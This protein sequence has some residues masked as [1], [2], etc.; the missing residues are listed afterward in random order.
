MKIIFEKEELLS[1]LTPAMSA[2]SEKNTN[3]AI[4]GILFDAVSGGECIISSYDLEKGFRVKVEANVIEGGSYIIPA[5]KLFRIIKSMP[6]NSVSIEVNEKNLVKIVSGKSEFKLS[7]ING[8]DF[9][10]MP[11]LNIEI[12]FGIAGN[13]LK[14]TIS[15]IQHAIAQNEQ[16]RPVMQGAYF[17]LSNN[18]MLVV[19]TDGNRFALRRR[20]CELLDN[21]LEE[22]FNFII[23]GKTLNEL[24]KII[25][26][27]ENTVRINFG[28]KHV[29][30]VIGEMIFFSRL[31]EGDYIDYQRII[32]KTEKIVVK[33]NRD[34]LLDCLERVSLVSE[35]KGAGQVRSYVKCEFEGDLLKVSS[36]SSTYSVSDEMEISKTGEDIKIG[37]TCRYLIDALRSI[38]DDEVLLKMTSPLSLMAIC[39]CPETEGPGDEY[40]Y[41]IGPLKMKE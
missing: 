3:V 13:V 16:Q 22:G 20:D 18:Q 39:R 14:K 30:F 25:P 19:S 9:P 40:L 5:S 33:L 37:F 34:I 36:N 11:E 17:N 41:I 35:E 26:D 15:S 8:S 1:C 4:A 21:S 23:P 12:G 31:I 6:E 24:L 27:S 2:V 38:E 28:R 10:T 32:P 29:I 7:A